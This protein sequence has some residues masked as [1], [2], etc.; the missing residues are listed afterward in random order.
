MSPRIESSLNA[1]DCQA[2]LYGEPLLSIAR[3]LRAA[4]NT[5]PSIQEGA[6]KALADLVETGRMMR[7]YQTDNDCLAEQ[8]W[9]D[10]CG[11]AARWRREEAETNFD[12]ALNAAD[13]ARSGG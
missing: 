7:E 11:R 13:K 6:E 5:R 8:Q 9:T 12:M 2:Q 1:L 4:L 10:E 3:D